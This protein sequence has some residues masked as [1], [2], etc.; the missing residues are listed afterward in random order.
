MS[1]SGVEWARG[2]DLAPLR[3]PRPGS[4]R[5]EAGPPR[6]VLGRSGSTLVAAE[7]R[8]S[9]MVFGPT[10]SG[11]TTG[12]AIPALLDW[13]GPVV[14][15][16]VKRDLLDHTMAARSALGE[17][18]LFDPTGV[19]GLPASGWSP[20]GA[21]RTWP[22]ARRMAA[23]LTEG[24]R[25]ASSGAEDAEFW[26]RSA[27]KLAAPLLLAAAGTRATMDD[28]L[29]WVDGQVVA[30]VIDR[31]VELDAT[32]AIRAARAIFGREER[33]RSSVYA[34]LETVLEPFVGLDRTEP[35]LD[36]PGWLR[37]GTSTLYLCAPAHDQRRL[38]PLFV[39]VI[40]QI[41]E[42][43]YD[44]VAHSRRPLDPPLLLVLDEAANIAPLDDLD[45][46]AATAAGHG[47]QLVTIWHDLAQVTARYGGRAMTVANNHRARLFL[48]GIADPG[49]LE[50]ASALIGDAMTR[51]SSTTSGG[52]SGRSVTTSQEHHRLI[53]P[54]GLRRTPAGQGVLVYGALPP[55]R[56]R[57]RPFYEDRRKIH[58]A[59]LRG[60]R[61][62]T[63]RPRVAGQPRSN[64]S[65]HR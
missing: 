29:A 22:G 55:V 34:T 60:D 42:A 43:A 45:G 40:R 20:L 13:A 35:V 23:A 14:A 19:T 52:P 16:S 39:G 64:R 6:L 10:Q 59:P 12:L 51:R 53:S 9:V 11:K 46:L 63:S 5:A 7:A 1:H 44:E 36:D 49:T 26:Y 17:V 24:G 62:L 32:E 57:L 47:I 27:A 61:G 54:D 18:R 25:M 37:A 50:Y 31:L 48:S 8:A 2:R 28:V 15:A 41:V 65:S 21:S 38:A 58:P 33:Q 4:R 3:V 30:E 56:L